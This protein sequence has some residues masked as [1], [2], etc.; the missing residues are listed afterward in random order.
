MSKLLYLLGDADRV[1]EGIDRLLL[2]GK[3]EELKVFSTALTVAIAELVKAFELEMDAET[4]MAGGDDVLFCVA[5]EKYSPESHLKIVTHFYESTGCRISFGIASNL[6]IAYINLRRA[7]AEKTGICA[8]E[9][10]H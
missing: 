4:L 8:E 2:R 1:R 5:E 7:K 9:S 10:I 3:L 6:P